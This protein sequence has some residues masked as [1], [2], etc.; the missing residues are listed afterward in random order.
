MIGLMILAFFFVVIIE[1]I[2]LAYV[3]QRKWLR[4]C[5]IVFLPMIAY[6][7]LFFGHFIKLFIHPVY[8]YIHRNEGIVIH[9]SPE[10]WQEIKGQH[11]VIK[12]VDEYNEAYKYS[13]LSEEYFDFNYEKDKIFSKK[14]YYLDKINTK[15]PNLTLYVNYDGIYLG[16]DIS[17]KK[18]YIAY[19]ISKDS[20]LASFSEYSNPFVFLGGYIKGRYECKQ[21]SSIDELKD[22]INENYISSQ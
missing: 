19:D 1:T 2:L 22:Y 13:W 10:K 12:P 17:S 3:I 15:N 9:T 16:T 7:S 14:K 20:I 4:Y 11:F 8:C 21:P 5:V 18:T 6:F